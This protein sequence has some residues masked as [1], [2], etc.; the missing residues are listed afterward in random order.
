MREVGVSG[1]ETVLLYS[2]V[3]YNVSFRVLQGFSVDYVLH[4]AHKYNEAHEYHSSFLKMRSA[5]TNIGPS[6]ISASITTTGSAIF[7]VFCQIYIFQQMG[8]LLIAN[9]VL[10]IFVAMLTFTSILSVCGPRGRCC[11]MYASCEKRKKK[12]K[13]KNIEMAKRSQSY[14]VSPASPGAMAVQNLENGQIEVL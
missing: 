6:I 9:T 14:M 7:L 2:H 5:I 12:K 10:A 8:W 3:I 13:K 4:I 1:G 11:D